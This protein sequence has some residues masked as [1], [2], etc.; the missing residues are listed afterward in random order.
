MWI[1]AMLRWVGWSSD[2][3]ISVP[4]PI[5][6]PC[7]AR[8]CRRCADIF[9]ADDVADCIWV[10]HE[11]SVAEVDQHGQEMRVRSCMHAKT[12]LTYTHCDTGMH[13]L[14][15]NSHSAAHWRARCAAGAGAL[16]DGA[17]LHTASSCFRSGVRCTRAAAVEAVGLPL[18]DPGASPSPQEG[19]APIERVLTRMCAAAAG[20][21]RGAWHTP[22]PAGQ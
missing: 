1:L 19:G 16:Q 4:C 14:T 7:R 9:D 22:L 2:A 20:I 18:L 13:A 10:L 3:D 6:W 17:A 12:G 8:S 5:G 15:H 11:G 21:P